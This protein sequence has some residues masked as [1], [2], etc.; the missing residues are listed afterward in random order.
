[1]ETSRSLLDKQAFLP[2]LSGFNNPSATLSEQGL[3][4]A[5][6]TLTSF[7]S[8]CELLLASIDVLETV[9]NIRYLILGGPEGIAIETHI[10]PVL[11]KLEAHFSLSQWQRKDSLS[12]LLKPSTKIR[13]H[14]AV[15]YSCTFITSRLVEAINEDN[16]ASTIISLSF[17]LCVINHLRQFVDHN[18][19][20]A[21]LMTLFRSQIASLKA[22]MILVDT[23]ELTLPFC[24]GEFANVF[25]NRSLQTVL[26]QYL[27]LIQLWNW[28]NQAESSRPR[29][30][31]DTGKQSHKKMFGLFKRAIQKS[32]HELETIN[33]AAVSIGDQFLSSFMRAAETINLQSLSH[34]VFEYSYISPDKIILTLA[35]T[36]NL[37][38]Y[39]RIAIGFI[40]RPSSL[41]RLLPSIESLI[42]HRHHLSHFLSQ[43]ELVL[44]TTT[45]NER[46][47]IQNEWGK[48]EACLTSGLMTV[49][50]NSPDFPRFAD[51]CVRA[52]KDLF[53]AV[54]QLKITKG[55]LE[56]NS[57]ILEREICS[58]QLPVGVVSI[59]QIVE[60]AKKAI[61]KKTEQKRSLDRTIAQMEQS[62]KV[63]HDQ[64]VVDS[65]TEYFNKFRKESMDR[66]IKHLTTTMTQM[67]DHLK[68]GLVQIELLIVLGGVEETNGVIT[69]NPTLEFYYPAETSQLIAG[70][71]KSQSFTPL[72]Y[73]FSSFLYD[74][75]EVVGLS[76]QQISGS[77][78]KRSRSSTKMPEELAASIT[79]LIELMES[80]SKA[81]YSFMMTFSSFS[82]LWK[83]NGEQEMIK[84]RK[85]EL[86][87]E[88]E[89][90]KEQAKEDME[91]PLA[92]SR[93]SAPSDSTPAKEVQELTIPE[94]STEWSD[95]TFWVDTHNSKTENQFKVHQ[96]STRVS[97]NPPFSQLLDL[98]S[99]VLQLSTL[100]SSLTSSSQST[101]CPFITFSLTS[102]Q[103][104]L[105]SLST[106]FLNPFVEYLASSLRLS[107]Q[108]AQQT[109]TSLQLLPSL[110]TESMSLPSSLSLCTILRHCFTVPSTFTSYIV[111]LLSRTEWAQ[112]VLGMKSERIKDEISTLQATWISFTSNQLV[113]IQHQL[114]LTENKN[115][116]LLSAIEEKFESESEKLH[117]HTMHKDYSP[118]SL[119][120]SPVSAFERLDA[121]TVRFQQL[122][123]E[124][125]SLHSLH[126]LLS[127]PSH[128]HSHDL[129]EAK[130]IIEV[131]QTVWR[132]VSKMED[133]MKDDIEQMS[134][135]VLQILQQPIKTFEDTLKTM[136]QI[137]FSSAFPIF[138][139]FSQLAQKNHT[140]LVLLNQMRAHPLDRHDWVVI[141]NI[142]KIDGNKQQD[143]IPSALSGEIQL[144]VF[145]DSF[146]MNMEKEFKRVLK[147]WE[148]RDELFSIIND[149]I[150]YYHSLTLPLAETSWELELHDSERLPAS[151]FSIVPRPV[152]TERMKR[153]E[154]KRDKPIQPSGKAYFPHLGADGLK[155]LQFVLMSDSNDII[156][157]IGEKHSKEMLRAVDFLLN[158]LTVLSDLVR[159]LVSVNSTIQ[160]LHN[161]FLTGIVPVSDFSPDTVFPLMIEC[162]E[163]LQDL[164]GGDIE[165]IE[166][167]VRLLQQL[168]TAL[169]NQLRISAIISLPEAFRMTPYR[170]APYLVPPPSFVHVISSYSTT[171]SVPVIR[172]EFIQT[173]VPN[174]IGI[175]T[176]HAQMRRQFQSLNPMKPLNLKCVT[177]YSSSMHPISLTRYSIH[178]GFNSNFYSFFPNLE[179]AI[180][181]ELKS[182]FLTLISTLSQGKSLLHFIDTNLLTLLSPN[183]PFAIQSIELAISVW[184]SSL[185]IQA[186]RA[187]ETNRLES[188]YTRLLQLEDQTK[189]VLVVL[190]S[191]QRY[192][193]ICHN[194]YAVLNTIMKDVSHRLQ[195]EGGFRGEQH[196][197]ESQAVLM[198]DDGEEWGEILFQSMNG[199]DD[200][201]EPEINED[202]TEMTEKEE[203]FRDTVRELIRI[204][205]T[206]VNDCQLRRHVFE[207]LNIFPSNLQA[208]TTSL[209][210]PPNQHDL[211]LILSDLS[212]NDVSDHSALLKV[213][214]NSAPFVFS[215]E[216]EKITMRFPQ[217]DMSLDQK[218]EWMGTEFGFELLPPIS[219]YS[220]PDSFSARLFRKTL[221]ACFVDS[222]SSPYVCAGPIVFVKDV[223]YSS[224]HRYLDSYASSLGLVLHSIVCAPLLPFQ[225]L[226]QLIYI[227]I[228]FGHSIVLEH[229]E[230]LD[231]FTRR[232][233]VEW[234]KGVIAFKKTANR[235][236]EFG[237]KKVEFSLDELSSEIDLPLR[238]TII[239]ALYSSTTSYTGS[240][241]DNLSEVFRVITLP[242]D[243]RENILT[244]MLIEHG[245]VFSQLFAS[246]LVVF[247]S[248]LLDLANYQI[249]DEHQ[250]LQVHV[251]S[252]VF[253]QPLM[254]RAGKNLRNI[255]QSTRLTSFSQETRIDPHLIHN[256]LTL[257]EYPLFYSAP[258]LLGSSLTDP[259]VVLQI[260][261]EFEEK[262]IRNALFESVSELLSASNEMNLQ[263]KPQRLF[264]GDE[265]WIGSIER[266]VYRLVNATFTNL[267]DPEMITLPS[268]SEHQTHRKA[269]SRHP[270]RSSLSQSSNPIVFPSAMMIPQIQTDVKTRHHH[271]VISYCN[272]AGLSTDSLFLRHAVGLYNQIKRCPTAIVTGPPGSGKTIVIDA[273]KSIAEHELRTQIVTVMFT[274][275]TLDHKLG[276]PKKLKEIQKK[277]FFTIRQSLTT[278][279]INEFGEACGQYFKRHKP[280]DDV[281]NSN[282]FTQISQRSRARPLEYL[283]GQSKTISR[284]L[285]II[286]RAHLIN[287][288]SPPSN[289]LEII[290]GCSIVQSSASVVIVSPLM[291]SIVLPPES[292]IIFETSFSITEISPFSSI[293]SPIFTITTPHTAIKDW[294]ITTFV[295]RMA[296]LVPSEVLNASLLYLRSTTDT[297]L[298]YLGAHHYTVQHSGSTRINVIGCYRTCAGLLTSLIMLHSKNVK[299][300]IDM[301]LMLLYSAY[302]LLWGFFGQ[303]KRSRQRTEKQN[304]FSFDDWFHRWKEKHHSLNLSIAHVESALELQENV[305]FTDD[306]VT[307]TNSDDDKQ[308][309]D[310]ETFVKTEF[311][312]DMAMIKTGSVFD[313]VPDPYEKQLVNISLLHS[314]NCILGPS[315]IAEMDDLPPV[316]K[317]YRPLRQILFPS[318]LLSIVHMPIV[319]FE[320]AGIT[321]SLFSS[322]IATIVGEMASFI[323]PESAAWSRPC[324]QTRHVTRI[325]FSDGHTVSNHSRIPYGSWIKRACSHH[326]LYTCPNCPTLLYVSST[327]D[328][329]PFNAIVGLADSHRTQEI[330]G[331][332]GLVR[333]MNST[334]PF[335]ISCS[336]ESFLNTRY[337]DPV[338]QDMSTFSF[339]EPEPE[340]Y[341][342]IALVILR[343]GSI[344]MHSAF[345]AIAKEVI[346]PACV[347]FHTTLFSVGNGLLKPTLQMFN[348]LMTGL[349][350]ASSSC[351]Q[352]PQSLIALWHWQAHAVY[353]FSQPTSRLYDLVRDKVIHTSRM[354]FVTA[355]RQSAEA[356]SKFFTNEPFI[357][358]DGRLVKP[359]LFKVVR[360]DSSHQ[361]EVYSPT[362]ETNLNKTLETLAKSRSGSDA[363]SLWV[364][365]NLA[366][367]DYIERQLRLYQ[368][369]SDN[370]QPLIVCDKNILNELYTMRVTAALF[371]CSVTIVSLPSSIQNVAS[372]LNSL[373]HLIVDNFFDMMKQEIADKEHGRKRFAL[374]PIVMHR[375]FNPPISTKTVR[376]LTF[377]GYDSSLIPTSYRQTTHA[378]AFLFVLVQSLTP[379]TQFLVSLLAEVL[380]FGIVPTV[381]TN[382][383]IKVLEGNMMGGAMSDKLDSHDSCILH[384][385]RGITALL[386]KRGIAQPNTQQ[387]AALLT[388]ATKYIK[389]VFNTK[390][391]HTDKVISYLGHFSQISHWMHA[392]ELFAHMNNP[393]GQIAHQ[394][395]WTMKNEPLLRHFIQIATDMLMPTYLKL[396]SFMYNRQLQDAITTVQQLNYRKKTE[397]YLEEVISPVISMIYAKVVHLS[398]SLESDQ[399]VFGA[400]HR[401]P[402]FG[403]DTMHH[404]SIAS[405]IDYTSFFG[406]LLTGS[407]RY[408][409]SMVQNLVST[410]AVIV[411]FRQQV[412]L[413]RHDLTQIELEAKI[414]SVQE[415][416]RTRLE[417]IGIQLHQFQNDRSALLKAHT[418]PKPPIP[419]CQHSETMEQ[420]VINMCEAMFPFNVEDVEDFRNIS[421]IYHPLRVLS[422]SLAM[423]LSP[424]EKT[425][426]KVIPT[427]SMPLLNAMWSLDLTEVPF[428]HAYETN[429]RMKNDVFVDDLPLVPA[430][431]RSFH[432]WLIN[433]SQYRLECENLT[434]QQKI[435]AK[436][437][438]TYYT[439]EYKIKKVDILINKLLTEQE[440]LWVLLQAEDPEA[441]FLQT[442]TRANEHLV[443]AERFVL[444]LNPITLTLTEDLKSYESLIDTAIGDSVIAAAFLTL[445]S[446]F[447]D[448][449]KWLFAKDDMF[450]LLDEMNVSFSQNADPYV[451]LLRLDF[452][453]IADIASLPSSQQNKKIFDQVT[454]FIDVLHKQ[455]FSFLMLETSLIDTAHTSVLS[456]ADTSMNGYSLFSQRHFAFNDTT[457]DGV[458]STSLASCTQSDFNG[459]VLM[460]LTSRTLLGL[461]VRILYANGFFHSLLTL[462]HFHATR[463]VENPNQF[464][465]TVPLLKLPLIFDRLSITTNKSFHSSA[466]SPPNQ[467]FE[468]YGIRKPSESPF[469]I[470]LAS[471]SS[472][473]LIHELLNQISQTF[474]PALPQVPETPRLLAPLPSPSQSTIRSNREKRLMDIQNYLRTANGSVTTKRIPL[475]LLD[476]CDSTVTSSLALV[477]EALSMRFTTDTDSNH[478]SIT[479]PSETTPDLFTLKDQASKT[480]HLPVALDIILISSTDPQATFYGTWM[481]FI[482]PIQ[483]TP[484]MQTIRETLSTQLS[485]TI[486]SVISSTHPEF[487][488]R[489]SI[490][491]SANLTEVG[492]IETRRVEKKKQLVRVIKTLYDLNLFPILKV[493][494]GSPVDPFVLQPRNLSDLRTH[495]DFVEAVFIHTKPS[496]SESASLSGTPDP[497]SPT[498]KLDSKGSPSNTD[499][500][501]LQII[502]ESEPDTLSSVLFDTTSPAH[503]LIVPDPQLPA[504]SDSLLKAEILP[505]SEG[506]T[507]TEENVSF[508]LVS[509]PQSESIISFDIAKLQ[510]AVPE[511]PL[512][513][514]LERRVFI[515]FDDLS[516]G[517]GT[518]TQPPSQT[519]ASA[520]DSGPEEAISDEGFNEFTRISPR[521]QEKPQFELDNEL[522]WVGNSI[523]IEPGEFPALLPA[524]SPSVRS[525]PSE[526]HHSS[527]SGLEIPVLDDM[528]ESQHH[529]EAEPSPPLPFFSI[530]SPEMGETPNID[531]FD[532]PS[533]LSRAFLFSIDTQSDFLSSLNAFQP[534]HTRSGSP[535]FGFSYDSVENNSLDLY[536]KP[537][538]PKKSYS[539]QPRLSAHPRPVEET[540]A[541]KRE[542]MD[543]PLSEVL[544]ITFLLFHNPDSD[545]GRTDRI[546]ELSNALQ[547]YNNAEN[548]VLESLE[549][550]NFTFHWEWKN[551]WVY[552]EFLAIW[553]YG[554]VRTLALPFGNSLPLV[555][556]RQSFQTLISRYINI[557]ASVLLQQSDIH[558]NH[559][560]KTSH[561]TGTMPELSPCPMSAQL[562]S[563]RRDTIFSTADSE[564]MESPPFSSGHMSQTEPSFETVSSTG[565]FQTHMISNMSARDKMKEHQIRKQIIDIEAITDSSHSPFSLPKFNRGTK[566]GFSEMEFHLFTYPHSFVVHDIKSAM[567]IDVR[568]PENVLFESRVPFFS[569]MIQLMLPLESAVLQCS[570]LM[571]MNPASSWLPSIAWKNIFTLAALCPVYR[572]L[573]QDLS[574]AMSSVFFVIDAIPNTYPD[575]DQVLRD[576]LRRS[577]R[578]QDRV[579]KTEADELARFEVVS[580]L[581]RE[582]VFTVLDDIDSSRKQS[583]GQSH[584][585]K[586][587]D[588]LQQHISSVVS[589]FSQANSTLPT[590][591]KNT[592]IGSQ[593]DE[594]DVLIQD[595]AAFESHIKPLS[596]MR[597]RWE[598]WYHTDNPEQE[599]FPNEM[600]THLSSPQ[601]LLL[602]TAILPSRTRSAISDVIIDCPFLGLD[603]AYFDMSLPSPQKNTGHH[604]TDKDSFM[605]VSTTFFLDTFLIERLTQ[606]DLVGAEGPSGKGDN[607]HRVLMLS[608]PNKD[609]LSPAWSQEVIGYIEEVA[610]QKKMTTYS[611]NM[612][613][614][615]RH[616]LERTLKDNTSQSVH[617]LDREQI[618]SNSWKMVRAILNKQFSTQNWL[619]VEGLEMTTPE[620]I[621]KFSKWAKRKYHQ[622]SSRR[623]SFLWILMTDEHYLN[624]DS[625]ITCLSK[626]VADIALHHVVRVPRGFRQAL[627]STL[628]TS[629]QF[630]PRKTLTH[631]A[632][633]Y[634]NEADRNSFT[635][636]SLVYLTGAFC[637]FHSSLIEMTYREAGLTNT[638][639]FRIDSRALIR[640]LQILQQPTIYQYTKGARRTDASTP[641]MWKMKRLGEI[642]ITRVYPEMLHYFDEKKMFMLIDRVFNSNLFF[643]GQSLPLLPSIVHPTN[644]SFI[645]SLAHFATLTLTNTI[646]QSSAET[647]KGIVVN[648]VRTSQQILA[649]AQTEGSLIGQLLR[650]DLELPTVFTPLFV[651]P[652]ST[653]RFDSFLN[654]DPIANQSLNH[655][656]ELSLFVDIKTVLTR[657]TRR[658]TLNLLETPSFHPIILLRLIQELQMLQSRLRV[659][660][661][662]ATFA[663]RPVYLSEDKVP[664][665]VAMLLNELVQMAVINERIG[666]FLEEI[667]SF[668]SSS[669]E[670]GKLQSTDD[671]KGM[672]LVESMPMIV[673]TP[674]LPEV[675][676]TRR[677]YSS[678][679]I[680]IWEHLGTGH[681]PLDWVHVDPG[682]FNHQQSP[683]SPDTPPRLLQWLNRY[684]LAAQQL[685]RLFAFAPMVT[686]RFGSGT[687]GNAFN[688]QIVDGAAI[689][690]Y[691]TIDPG[692]LFNPA[693]WLVGYRIEMTDHV[694][695]HLLLSAVRH[696]KGSKL[697]S[698][699]TAPEQPERIRSIKTS[700]YSGSMSGLSRNSTKF[701]NLEKMD[702][703]V[704]TNLVHIWKYRTAGSV[705]SLERTHS[706]GIIAGNSS[707]FGGN[708]SG[709]SAQSGMP[710]ESKRSN[711]L[712]KL[713]SYRDVA[714]SL[715]PTECDT[716]QNLLTQRPAKICTFS[717]FFW[718]GTTI[719]SGPSSRFSHI[720]NLIT[721]IG[722]HHSNTFVIRPDKLIPNERKMIRI[723]TQPDSSSTLNSF[724][725]N[726]KEKQHAL[727]VLQFNVIVSGI[728][729]QQ[730]SYAQHGSSLHNIQSRQV[731]ISF[732]LSHRII[733]NIILLVEDETETIARKGTE[734]PPYRMSLGS[735]DHS[736]APTPFKRPW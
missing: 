591:Q 509:H 8:A 102:L 497:N 557:F 35:D 544:S 630:L 634:D 111:S 225:R 390:Y 48:V 393:G 305:R 1:M 715:T 736:L 266:Q 273:S 89:R 372:F 520:P 324:N 709:I 133:Y 484:S 73:F 499:S 331:A 702:A 392:P 218:G 410:I 732:S 482:D 620:F 411:K 572:P 295:R 596:G 422:Q 252:P 622:Q 337:F 733:P 302:S 301:K 555:L 560:K 79:E 327:Q 328:K 329:D 214:D 653:L 92:F 607:S 242:Q 435:Q 69:G 264:Q 344:K 34:T 67:V 70:S 542:L 526:S 716:A 269:R 175:E 598:Q 550:L 394:A 313:Y 623:Q 647:A 500:P 10:Q 71:G 267:V 505:D 729:Q 605:M 618:W 31:W 142:L 493:P 425:Q 513:P 638:K 612:T 54:R 571:P 551:V 134:F 140:I 272:R 284:P 690:Q 428:L 283:T 202:E 405:Y 321:S 244:S 353:D 400:T 431:A 85:N 587:Q 316:I 415:L 494:Y 370:A 351:Y 230:C 223:E 502:H 361:L 318:A 5:R 443:Q 7:C 129:G 22:H 441:L 467:L 589:S 632:R 165:R 416:A 224:A 418:S 388:L 483:I 463:I 453:S 561:S 66:C 159:G 108:K 584:H 627:V 125:K 101:E 658:D 472:L 279:A 537:P 311:G 190:M 261:R 533:S 234:L 588:E 362:E 650:T 656:R 417:S 707:V 149:T 346:I 117:K 222:N 651:S 226:K 636:R 46:G 693:G 356:G 185:L 95:L 575:A 559:F 593:F 599:P 124:E 282:F 298:T 657:S 78:S 637:A 65:Y 582:A 408:Y 722:D 199:M 684:L 728:D 633:F 254:A 17:P 600:I 188:C 420:I 304:R 64:K 698:S 536:D 347:Y 60:L 541:Q 664:P 12:I 84:L 639:G 93:P 387:V 399:S 27:F 567:S 477:F 676:I 501:S 169:M 172:G 154:R 490:Q 157:I 446:R 512:D 396:S 531:S 660:V 615:F 349:F 687:T 510:R 103:Q 470:S 430:L 158:T 36:R 291:G 528:K 233:L 77:R 367:S 725:T 96:N 403:L 168:N 23:R 118:I 310:I 374:P 383:W 456:Y 136:E 421:N 667:P 357:K 76:A 137:H 576:I 99:S 94:L 88:E 662:S 590:Q 119:D 424:K 491:F 530:G 703:L 37:L 171:T 290:C 38:L 604:S 735:L 339:T 710:N 489:H 335:I 195:T 527:Q 104:S 713:I 325:L 377:F 293:Q 75:V 445:F 141:F 72:I 39:I 376:P 498:D 642:I 122:K 391:T 368:I 166:I 232:L 332:D 25:G 49:M 564:I 652:A 292:K 131:L 341:A 573:V 611:I 56:Q 220:I 516:G 373:A 701:I 177:L 6:T 139:E 184:Y 398:R 83:V 543:Q 686:S 579:E 300:Q 121:L 334:H 51:R 518:Q 661:A 412:L 18:L 197:K 219:T 58:F 338:S 249:K 718:V 437:L 44:T 161:T 194:N 457:S 645:P 644:D 52:M 380:E 734:R 53:H 616:Q 246:K 546:F 317:E 688:D 574:E 646:S 655:R 700:R 352:S 235:E 440:S 529:E 562:L 114:Q 297:I 654:S 385:F 433:A 673:P 549:W 635:Y 466:D 586:E 217:H 359:V 402:A 109:L 256:Y 699:E 668:F 323:L 183:P 9:K 191:I 107:I 210:P 260:H 221:S 250:H 263:E 697:I 115:N 705:L 248:S 496:N 196:H 459:H 366:K 474:Y 481:E 731:P 145:I 595:R 608:L 82:D 280:L 151:H 504:F 245:F 641:E 16:T 419:P 488:M 354:F 436:Q 624:P 203:K 695:Q 309:M 585:K 508:D 81:S 666:S 397:G 216:D 32:T 152:K 475:F 262:A 534:I 724:T 522:A 13:L 535:Q 162:E 312:E 451:F 382:D 270:S 552:A 90:R 285:W 696:D 413:L 602:F 247:F 539:S 648:S 212:A 371:D 465:L 113:L 601:K 14:N 167:T 322:Y 706:S 55:R 603:A 685:H 68:A 578:N 229:L 364:H 384:L 320:D 492:L 375:S 523:M 153:N 692:L 427:Q 694:N 126:A 643:G 545:E 123:D 228:A 2:G 448:A 672:I 563:G 674:F 569:E 577:S 628:G 170:F 606:P 240:T 460:T 423:M 449:E 146:E 348:A 128:M 617:A 462:G 538:V 597:L 683:L 407:V 689:G 678:S 554:Y 243:N 288:S 105:L 20:A 330:F 215:P 558:L 691:P 565:D 213:L 130:R 265:R 670:Q 621:E 255:I 404:P 659:S 24:V 514:T 189:E 259:A 429:V 138:Q 478:L 570:G 727:P 625:P 80:A 116:V 278:Q 33:Q 511:D 447:T 207:E 86:Q 326:G 87:K 426:V 28:S 409:N 619:I 15:S 206:Y 540:I 369:F 455:S 42:T 211:D 485:R 464:Q 135:G 671:S 432:R 59:N 281:I 677:D 583:Y 401:D 4:E 609:W 160:A 580:M 163:Q 507:E 712:I 200:T 476:V 438:A 721:H 193:D 148:E 434:P 173:L 681:V 581:E 241:P 127:K 379:E 275:F 719:N 461:F 730:Y 41:S 568:I 631:I 164:T 237:R 112:N 360:K 495:T 389:I 487:A 198:W 50:W 174:C 308:I 277:L 253:L 178:L 343:Q 471:R 680:Q 708:S 342:E 682:I 201:D 47:C 97:P 274:P 704:E 209:T 63:D 132:E 521:N 61:E 395:H 239:S 176:D 594:T 287:F 479:I 306:E 675:N 714:L 717:R 156:R 592:A 180:K 286:L 120:E 547:E 43:R 450:P 314:N 187:L 626:Y 723:D 303:M 231:Q 276:D 40:N 11:A 208:A 679:F 186:R 566:R 345:D 480:Y 503:N 29:S 363:Y 182:E 444:S 355:L 30:V 665:S 365:S 299:T 378:K 613:V 381:G 406:K 294:L 155:W 350:N 251:Y 515:D 519:D 21:K 340:D 315:F 458:S 649:T 486:S 336:D 506:P 525:S 143:L 553:V 473:A 98:L 62:A 204:V 414:N 524:S 548:E 468:L 532:D 614:F 45:S 74:F 640:F 663:L 192:S 629:S 726:V 452:D 319:L 386:I 289:F 669:L 517:D 110:L 150:M 333:K 238:P 205:L 307:V 454:S 257:V 181:N 296:K 711:V 556:R 439:L 91:S 469:V 144:K 3:T 57:D 19:S 179:S 271:L 358:E 147:D 268:Q 227:H 610:K 26:S 106:T 100:I 258:H 236:S 720:H 442:T